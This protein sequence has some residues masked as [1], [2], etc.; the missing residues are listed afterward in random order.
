[1]E[2]LGPHDSDGYEL[3][4]QCAVAEAGWSWPK[5]AGAYQP[6]PIW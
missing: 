1:M 3:R 5:L 4:F 6:R 2:S